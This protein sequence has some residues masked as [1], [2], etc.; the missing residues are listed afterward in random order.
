M[1]LRGTPCPLNFIRCKLALERLENN[2]LLQVDLDVGEPES[3]V[4]FGL[5]D[6]GHKVEIVGYEDDWMRVLVV[7]NCG[8]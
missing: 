1:D 7:N 3:M 8:E 6:A 5:R 4:I 2:E